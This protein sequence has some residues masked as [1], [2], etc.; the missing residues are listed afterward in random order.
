MGDKF[1]LLVKQNDLPYLTVDFDGKCSK[2]Y[3][4]QLSKY[5]LSQHIDHPILCSGIAFIPNTAYTQI[6]SWNELPRI[7]N[8]DKY[9]LWDNFEKVDQG[10]IEK[11]TYS[12][13]LK[14]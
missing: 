1:H 8:S 12:P 7:V 4:K 6:I 13:C 14:D 11:I 5:F 10:T 3:L 2:E 9:S